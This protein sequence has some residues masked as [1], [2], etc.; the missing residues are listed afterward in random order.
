MTEEDFASLKAGL[1]DAIAF[2]RGEASRGA[3][4]LAVDVKAIRKAANKTQREFAAA[5]HLPIGTVRDWEQGRRTP[6]A[7]AKALLT[8]IAKAPK[9]AELFLA[10]AGNGLHMGKGHIKALPAD[11]SDPEDRD[12]CAAGIERGLMGRRIRMLRNK[13]C[14][15]QDQFAK[16]F[17]IPIANIRQYE[18]GKIMPPPAVQ[19]YLKVIEADPVIAAKAQHGSLNK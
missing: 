3:V 6:D 12:V 8:V 19:A 14:L 4:H 10:H 18:I 15:S 11:T 16:R 1:E 2:M 5:Y 7:P 9:E 17:G 13:L